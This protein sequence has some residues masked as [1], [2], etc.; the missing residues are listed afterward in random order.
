M[1][2]NLYLD[3]THLAPNGDGFKTGISVVMNTDKETKRS[4][5]S[6]KS[7]EIDVEKAQYILDLRDDEGSILDSVSITGEAYASITGEP[8]LTTEE[9]IELDA[10]FWGGAEKMLKI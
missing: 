1:S 6:Y 5:L 3:T 8:V 9:Y 7:L 4:F 10:A 2:N